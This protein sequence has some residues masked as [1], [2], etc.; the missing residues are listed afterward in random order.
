MT[1]Q[2]KYH[3]KSSHHFDSR[4]EYYRACTLGLLEKAGKI[5][6]LRRQ[7][8]YELIPAQKD[9]SGRVVER[10]CHYVADFVYT[11]IATGETIVED[12]KGFRTPEYR[13]KRKLMRFLLNI[14]I[15][16]T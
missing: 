14:K 15:N 1:P 8:R 12:V 2:N 5:K 11:D 3:A 16:E 13:I 9:E 7:V 10:A 6:D 4:K